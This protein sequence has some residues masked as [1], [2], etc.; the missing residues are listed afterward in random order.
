MWWGLSFCQSVTSEYGHSRLFT[1][2]RILMLLPLCP[3][4]PFDS[5]VTVTPLIL[6]SLLHGVFSV[7]PL[8]GGDLQ[9]INAGVEVVWR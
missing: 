7:F 2:L 9:G 5:T 1:D 4:G 8:L 6:L 3:Q